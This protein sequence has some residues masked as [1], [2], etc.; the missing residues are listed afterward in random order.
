VSWVEVTKLFLLASHAHRT[1]RW[2][3]IYHSTRAT[4]LSTRSRFT[5]S[6]QTQKR[7]YLDSTEFPWATTT[8]DKWNIKA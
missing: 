8:K 5:M 2:P 7:M 4:E 3:P 1:N 6:T